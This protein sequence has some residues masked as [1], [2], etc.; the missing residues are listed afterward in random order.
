MSHTSDWPL[1]ERMRVS[2]RRP[3]RGR[4]SRSTWALVAA[5]FVTGVLLSAIAFSVGWRQQAQQ[6]SSA[7]AELAVANAKVRTLG[8]SL[9]AARHAT[10]QAQAQ[11]AAARKARTAAASAARTVSHDAASLAAGLVASGKSAD[12]VSSGAA[13]IG[14]GVDRLAGELK[15]LT[16]YL[17]TTP[18]SQLDAGYIATQ[19]SYLAKQLDE[20][21]AARSDLAAAISDFN[22][23]AK[24][25]ADRAAVL[26]GRD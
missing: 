11:L 15:T 17:T 10:A 8:T 26:S 1:D 20:L 12:S 3:R 14:A 6:G 16:S 22:A 18:A 19:A 21:K 5:A 23:S 25:L 4:L 9:A 24:K 13:S 7:R 2:A